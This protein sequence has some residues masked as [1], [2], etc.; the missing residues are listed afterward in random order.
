MSK[1]LRSF[2]LTLFPRATAEE[3]PYP[4]VIS[5]V[6]GLR[7]METPAIV[8]LMAKTE[9]SVR[10]LVRRM[11]LPE[12]RTT[13][14]LHDAIMILI[15]RIRDQMFDPS[16][17][18][19]PTYVIGV[20]KKLAANHQRHQR[21]RGVAEPMYE[22]E[23]PDQYFDDF[24]ENRERRELLEYLLKEIGEP[25]AQLIR[26][27]YLDGYRDEEILAQNLTHYKTP[28]ALRSK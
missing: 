24:Q 14:I 9:P 19:P 3:N 17:S 20:A 11:K 12:S 28:M 5:W 2:Y 15:K 22:A 25:C 21:T 8:L 6:E 7:A 26:L 1:I 23:I 10:Q 18:A 13:D 16:Q 27:K 4:D